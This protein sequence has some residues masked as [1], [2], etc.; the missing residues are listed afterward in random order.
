MQIVLPASA[1]LRLASLPLVIVMTC[2]TSSCATKNYT[3]AIQNA[4]AE[5]ASAGK[6][7][8]PSEGAIPCVGTPLPKGPHPDPNDYKVFGALQTGQLGVC[9]TRRAL[10]YNTMVEHNAA[11]DRLV[12]KLAPHHWWE[13]WR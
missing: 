6:V 10:N 13:F 8:V 9:E 4:A 1:P 3:K 12:V 2:F 11:I 7:E 5:G